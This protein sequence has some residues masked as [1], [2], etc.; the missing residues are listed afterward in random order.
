MQYR[1][2]YITT[3]NEEE[4]ARIEKGWPDYLKRIDQSI[5]KEITA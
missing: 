2:I 1:V 3:E 4:V 5:E